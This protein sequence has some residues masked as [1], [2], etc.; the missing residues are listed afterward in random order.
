MEVIKKKKK[1][2]LGRKRKCNAIPAKASA[3]PVG[4]SGSETTLQNDPEMRKFLHESL[5]SSQP[6]EVGV[7]RCHE[8]A[9]WTILKCYNFS[10]HSWV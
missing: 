9:L 4:S 10:V 1:S 2:G 7:N 8:K 6:G 3:I 5:V